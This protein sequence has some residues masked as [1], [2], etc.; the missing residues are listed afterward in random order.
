MPLKSVRFDS[1]SLNMLR[2][3]IT[4]R[5]SKSRLG[6]NLAL[7]RA[8][9]ELLVHRVPTYRLVHLEQLS[10]ECV[11]QHTRGT[12]SAD[13][14]HTASLVATKCAYG[15]LRSFAICSLTCGNDGFQLSR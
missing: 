10:N 5:D 3:T 15:V 12:I 7:P 2:R 14:H 1:K 13:R 9:P 6:G 11:V 4:H 8:H